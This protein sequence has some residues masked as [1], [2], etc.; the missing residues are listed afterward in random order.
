M[1]DS[2]QREW[3]AALDALEAGIAAATDTH[4]DGILTHPQWH[5]PVNL[6]PIPADLVG[7]A[8]RIQDAQRHAI[9]ALQAAVR[10]NRQHYAM[11]SAVNA[12][13]ARPGAVYLD[14]AG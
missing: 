6:G 13:T 4:D 12:S 3:L 5:R 7:R 2:G 1:P 9:D 14:V 10:E 8:Q 11:V